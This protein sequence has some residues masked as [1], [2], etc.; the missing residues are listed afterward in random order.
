MTESA[1]MYDKLREREGAALDHA[2]VQLS[3]ECRSPADLLGAACA[4]LNHRQRYFSMAGEHGSAFDIEG[5][6]FVDDL[7]E[8]L[9]LAIDKV[10]SSR[11][12]G[13]L[14]AEAS[15]RLG[16]VLAGLPSLPPHPVGYMVIFLL[17]K[18][19][20]AFEEATRGMPREELDGL[21]QALVER[22]AEWVHG[23]AHTRATPLLR[24]MSDV[25]REYSVVARLSCA[26]G[27]GRYGVERQSLRTLPDGEHVDA[28]SIKCASCGAEREIEFPLPHFGDLSRMM[29]EGRG[30]TR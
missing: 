23:F 27:K 1:R 6:R 26:C 10:F 14:P 22:V 12:L 19:F 29:G 24:H 11:R 18:A 30:E 28:L 8:R 7:D 2:A 17:T 16:G 25:S 13:N 20:A 5:I 3:A 21:E 4:L 15:K 9:L